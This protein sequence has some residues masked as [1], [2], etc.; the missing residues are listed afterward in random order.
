MSDDFD[1]RARFAWRG[2]YYGIG[3]AI[4]FVLTVVNF[5]MLM[6]ALGAL[7]GIIAR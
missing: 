3:Q 6:R 7:A 1:E 4:G 5:Y 2:F